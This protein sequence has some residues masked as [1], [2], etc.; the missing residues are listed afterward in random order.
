[1][2]HL[3]LFLAIVISATALHGQDRYDQMGI[4]FKIPKGWGITDVQPEKNAI[5]FSCEKQ[6]D[7]E[8]GII[9]FIYLGVDADL[10]AFLQL[11]MQNAENSASMSEGKD[12]KWG[13][14]TT[15]AII[16]AYTARKVTYTVSYLGLPF[17]GSIMVY[18]GC[19]NMVML[20][21]QEADEDRKKNKRGFQQILGSIKCR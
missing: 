7:N 2:K 1:M 5:Y 10:N 9:S 18:R 6:G 4:T 20:N 19:G 14:D 21:P 11:C 12:F 8:S 13:P 3:L 15:D 16:G 17:S